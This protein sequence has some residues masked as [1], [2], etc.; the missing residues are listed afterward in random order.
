ML[1]LALYLS[2]WIQLK[3]GAS[4]SFA[5]AGL[6]H[7]EMCNVLPKHGRMK[8]EKRKNQ[9]GMVS[10]VGISSTSGRVSDVPVSDTQPF[11]TRFPTAVTGRNIDS[12]FSCS[13]IIQQQTHTKFRFIFKPYSLS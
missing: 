3:A 13:G 8:R 9:V 1:V 5:I 7:F 6:F 10:A 4:L 12:E 2:G 11:H